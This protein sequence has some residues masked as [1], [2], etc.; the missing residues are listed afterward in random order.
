M[1]SFF[2]VLDGGGWRGGKV[3]SAGRY[4]QRCA[5]SWDSEGYETAAQAHP[6]E[7]TPPSL[8][9]TTLLSRTLV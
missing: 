6:Y 9:N 5:D 1:Q 2:Q 4:V 8:R 7:V 3:W